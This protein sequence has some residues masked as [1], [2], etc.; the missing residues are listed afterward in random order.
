MLGKAV[1]ALMHLGYVERDT[2]NNS[3]VTVKKKSIYTR[4]DLPSK[5][6]QKYHRQMMERAIDALTTQD[7]SEREMISLTFS[8]KP[9]SLPRLKETLRRFRDEV[10]AEFTEESAAVYQLN[11]QLFAH[12]K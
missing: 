7:V 8:C 11:L 2:A 9:S 4:P 1:H 3:F 10:D 5:T 6:V 12:T